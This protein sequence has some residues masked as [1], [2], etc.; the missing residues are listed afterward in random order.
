DFAKRHPGGWLGDLLRPVMDTLRFVVGKN[1][2]VLPDSLSVA[3]ALT[4]AEEFGRRPGALLLVDDR[5]LLS[6]LFT[7]GDLRR[8][9]LRDPQGRNRPICD[10]MTRA[11]RTL[12]HTALVRDAVE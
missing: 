1:L 12:P 7:D 6:G 3:E 5:G 4:K 11:P 9:V 8:L 2:P 10:V